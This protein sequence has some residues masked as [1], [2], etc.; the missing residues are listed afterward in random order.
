MATR[1]ITLLGNSGNIQVGAFQDIDQDDIFDDPIIQ[2]VTRGLF[3]NNAPSL[4]TFFTSSAQSAS[5][6]QYYYDVY[7]KVGSD[8]TR[9]VQFAVA[10]GHALGSGSIVINAESNFA[11]AQDTPSRAI[12][13]QYVQTLLPSTQQKFS[14]IGIG[15]T[16]T[17]V[18]ENIIYVINFKRGRIKDLLDPGN[19][20]LNLRNGSNQLR[21][22]DDSRDTL[23]AG[24]QNSEFFNI[25]SG[26]LSAGIVVPSTT[27]TY[28]RVYPE[29]GVIV[30]SGTL[31]DSS[32]AVGISA[33]TNTNSNV[34]GNNAFKLFTYI[35]ASAANDPTNGA[36]KA[37]NV[38]EVKSTYYF[39]RAKNRDFNF[40]NNPSYV[41]ASGGINV[42]RQP[43]FA[44][45][46]KSYI[47][48]VGLYNSG[49]E[50]LAVGKL[51]KPILKSFGNEILLKVKL[52][53]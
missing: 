27:R 12:Y 2:K 42:L 32:S 9:E 5:S 21:L 11:G 39:L 53:F 38:E 17:A 47:T 48:T 52:D 24:N 18:D 26:S 29:R 19:F 50:M 43:T 8:S 14:F 10:Y 41:S 3:T 13:A 4:T 25:V 1:T 45:N 34:N 33:N 20:E 49:S 37:R 36:F 6:G 30:L 46:P 31:L 23:Q 28:G 35:S 40:S 44:N 16:G 22:I 7:D 15:G 51:S